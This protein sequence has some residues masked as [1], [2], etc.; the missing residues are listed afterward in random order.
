MNKKNNKNDDMR[1]KLMKNLGGNFLLWILIII[2]SVSVLQ[3]VSI[4]NNK[5]ELT[6]S[7]FTNL[8]KK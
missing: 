7:E 8:Y 6:Y 1:K 2:I 5:T 3:Y 4:N